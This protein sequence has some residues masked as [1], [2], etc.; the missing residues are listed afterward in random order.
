MGCQPVTVEAIPNPIF[1]FSHWEGGAQGSD[2]PITIETV[3]TLSITAVFVLDL[4]PIEGLYGEDSEQTELL[5]Y[6][7]D[8]VLS[9]TPEGQELIKLYYQWSPVIVK[10][11]EEDEKF[12]EQ[13]K[14]MIDG[15]LPLIR[16]E[17]E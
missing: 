8:N 17:V 4:C 5:R 9:Q 3:G 11:M 1:K 10:V 7:R 16:R 13:V 12:K 2:N 15:I 6:F 14:G